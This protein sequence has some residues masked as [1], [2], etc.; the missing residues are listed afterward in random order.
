MNESIDSLQ[1]EHHKATYHNDVVVVKRGVSSMVMALF[2]ECVD[3]IGLLTSL[4]CPPVR[5]YGAVL[6]VTSAYPV[7]CKLTICVTPQQPL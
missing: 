1:R 3:K 7:A 5:M 2:P 6:K 4:L